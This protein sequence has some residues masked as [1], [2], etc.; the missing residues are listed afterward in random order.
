MFSSVEEFPHFLKLFLFLKKFFLKD[1][2]KP[3]SY[4]RTVSQDFKHKSNMAVSDKTSNMAEG[5]FYSWTK[6]E[7]NIFKNMKD[8]KNIWLIIFRI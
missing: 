2:R 8:I 4:L 1:G 6:R 7:L 3:A 5:E